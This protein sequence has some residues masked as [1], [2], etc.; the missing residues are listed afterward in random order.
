ML[1]QIGFELIETMVKT[2][3]SQSIGHAQVVMAVAI[4]A[5]ARKVIILDL[6]DLSGSALLGIAAII[7]ALC[8]GYYLVKQKASP[9]ER[10]TTQES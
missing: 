7:L 2:C 8:V 3:L 6:N 5:I 4:I 9:G 1:I 10:T